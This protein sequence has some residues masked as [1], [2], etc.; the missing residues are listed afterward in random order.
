[1]II[2]TG[3]HRSG[4]SMVAGVLYHLGIYMGDDL[5]IDDID[6]GQTKEQPC[7]YFEDREF[8]RI[9]DTILQIANGAWNKIPDRERLLVACDKEN[10]ILDILLDKRDRNRGHALWG[11]KDPRTCL[12]LPA[13]LK[14]R[15]NNKI[16]IITRSK[17][18]VINSLVVRETWMSR[19]MASYLYESHLDY[20]RL[21]LEGTYH[22]ELSFEY[23]VKKR[24]DSLVE[25][26][27]LS[28]SNDQ[29]K[30]AISHIK[31]GVKA[32]K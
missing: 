25:F 32:S 10:N 12:T 15:S 1:M 11:F 5:M 3:M 24:I 7:G 17:E 26:L 31:P 22:L 13:Y 27:D 19:H 21:S 18:A 29:Y 23:L 6:Q 14:R 4:T 16:I 28:P 8:M 20:L 2:V 30:M 9:N